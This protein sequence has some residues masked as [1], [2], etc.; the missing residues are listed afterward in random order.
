[1]ELE[2]DEPKSCGEEPL[3]P[4]ASSRVRSRGASV[5][6]RLERGELVSPQEIRNLADC[7]LLRVILH[8]QR[9]ETLLKAAE[10]LMKRRVPARPSSE[11]MTR[12]RPRS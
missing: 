5:R 3:V 6:R 10:A 11:N 1:M 2:Q 8:D 4:L 12:P 9:P 7:A